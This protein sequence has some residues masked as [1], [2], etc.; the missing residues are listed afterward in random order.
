MNK[1]NQSYLV[2]FDGSLLISKLLKSVII[3]VF[4]SICVHVYIFSAY[5]YNE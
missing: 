3:A 5:M 4:T 1:D 2:I